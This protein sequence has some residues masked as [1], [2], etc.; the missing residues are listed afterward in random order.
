MANYD[1]RLERLEQQ[2]GVTKGYTRL[3]FVHRC[4]DGTAVVEAGGQDYSSA[5]GESS[6]DLLS[7]VKRHLAIEHQHLLVVD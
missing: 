5:P 3:L 6:G 1:A 4:D 7:R 2:L